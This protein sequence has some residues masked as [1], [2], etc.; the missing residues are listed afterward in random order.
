[1]LSVLGFASRAALIDAIVP[2]AIRAKA[3]LALPDPVDEAAAL[4]R[5]RAIAAKNRAADVVHRPGLLRHASR[6][7]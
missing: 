6:R 3:P 5:L 1:M 7:A 2:P 4:A